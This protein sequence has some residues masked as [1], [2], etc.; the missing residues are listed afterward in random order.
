MYYGT[1]KATYAELY[2]T[3]GTKLYAIQKM[4][5]NKSSVVMVEDISAERLVLAEL[6]KDGKDAIVR[7]AGA[8]RAMELAQTE[9]Y[10][11][12]IAFNWT[13]D[14]QQQQTQAK[15]KRNGLLIAGAALAVFALLKK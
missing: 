8:K 10:V 1:I 6:T 14:E 4:D 13:S 12:P 7:K 11:K 5:T 9:L 15:R 3:D 2:D